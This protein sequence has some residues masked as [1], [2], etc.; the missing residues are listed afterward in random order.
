M[1]RPFLTVIGVL[2]SEPPLPERHITDWLAPPLQEGG[3]KLEAFSSGGSI[4]SPWRADGPVPVAMAVKGQH[5]KFAELMP[6]VCSGS[7]ADL[8]PSLL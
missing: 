7:E 5:A 8:R 6:R 4:L 3:L 2:Q 1:K